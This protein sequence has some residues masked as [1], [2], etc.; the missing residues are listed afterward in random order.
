M[1]HTQEEKAIEFLTIGGEK[2]PDVFQQIYLSPNPY[3]DAFKEQLDIRRWHPND[4]PTAGLRLLEEDQRVIVVT[5]DP[6]T[7]AARIPRWRSR[8]KGAW[9]MQVRNSPI[10]TISDVRDALQ[11]T[12]TRGN[13]FCELLLAHAELKDGLTQD[14]IQ[15]INIDQLHT[16]FFLNENFLTK[17]QVPMVASGGVYN[18]VFSKLTRGKLLKQPD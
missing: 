5:M 12:H 15:Q 3:Y 6:S 10:Q 2:A 9:L 11:R 18:Y 7:P 1:E 14:G 13:Q 8:I 16:R 17:Q 4:H